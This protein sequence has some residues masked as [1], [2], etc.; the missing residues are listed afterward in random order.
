[1][2]VMPAYVRPTWNS[3]AVHIVDK[4]AEMYADLLHIYGRL[5]AVSTRLGTACPEEVEEALVICRM[6]MVVNG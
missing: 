5:T 1:V 4:H 6:T 3:P 2:T